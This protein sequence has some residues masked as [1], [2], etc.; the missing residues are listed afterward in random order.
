MACRPDEQKR[1]MVVPAVVIGRPAQMAA[2]RATLWPVA[3]SGPPQPSTTSSTSA[4][5]ILARA[6]ACWMAWPAMAAPWVL[7]N[8]PRPDL[9]RPVRA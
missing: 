8:P 5:S 2:L 9:A 1:L 3:P 6:T 4:A 7:L